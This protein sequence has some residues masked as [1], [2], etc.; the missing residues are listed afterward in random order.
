V[1]R[2][3]V[4]RDQ[5][6]PSQAEAAPAPPPGRPSRPHL[7]ELDVVRPVASLL[8]IITHT[9]QVFSNGGSV[10]YGAV[11][12]ESEASRHIFF[13]V[14][15]LVLTYQAY[16]RRRWSAWMFW[17]RRFTSI[18][19]P[20]ALWTVLYVV[21]GLAGL[22]GYTIPSVSGSPV[23]VLG[24][25]G[26]LLAT[27]PGHLYFVIVLMQFYLL[28][29]ALRWLLERTRRHHLHLVL[30][31]ASLAVQVALTIALHYGHL[32]P[33]VWQDISAIREVTSYG[34][35]LVTGAVAGAHLPQI[36]Q[37]TGR[38]RRLLLA[39]IAV[40]AAGV[41]TWYVMTVHSGV[42]PTTASDAF[43]PEL[44]V[45]YVADILLLWLAGAW[46]AARQRNGWPSRLIRTA[47][48]NSYGVYL[49]HAVFLDILITAGLGSL[50]PRVPWPFVVLIAVVATWVM[51]SL[52]IAAM[53][54]TPF[55]R[56]VSGR[57]RRPV[58]GGPP[59][60]GR[61]TVLPDDLTGGRA[62]PPESLRAESG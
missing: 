32:N 2:E 14:S 43:A 45:S 3:P 52:F 62:Q 48:D 13:F 57:A 54:R 44:I 31:L 37:W 28:F 56:W 27:G 38:H 59:P 51:A 30:V 33:T 46:W 49:S 39:G 24:Q 15:A 23:H 41:Q 29:P 26:V 36:R 5:I 47:S 22:R 8:V 7:D 6:R 21:L 10:F 20:F 42:S 16:G 55:S 25:I 53:A 34:F 4:L 60:V 18:Y 35:Y 11:L 9:M 1:L 50:E 19:L 61:G 12:L 40:A 58:I 17:R